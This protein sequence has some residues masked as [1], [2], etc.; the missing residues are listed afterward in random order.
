[1]S[2]KKLLLNMED[3][4]FEQNILGIVSSQS[5][6]EFVHFI[7]KTGHFNFERKE[8]LKVED[9]LGIKYFVQFIYEDFETNDIL[10]LIKTKGNAGIISK[11][12]LGIDYIL[13]IKSEDEALLGR[14]KDILEKQKS[15]MATINL[16][17]NKNF[18]KLKSLLNN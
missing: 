7:N 14:I 2:K 17:G 3:E 8:D 15:V 16:T 10:Q 5:H 9:P 1:M 6:L 11:E 18:E 4:A 13:L 12:L